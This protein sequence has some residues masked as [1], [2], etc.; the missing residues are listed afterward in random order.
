MPTTL[1]DLK[2]DLRAKKPL[3]LAF[4]SIFDPANQRQGEEYLELYPAGRTDCEILTIPIDWY[5][6]GQT[7]NWSLDLWYAKRQ[8]AD[9]VEDIRLSAYAFGASNDLGQEV[10][11]NGYLQA[12]LSTSLNFEPLNSGTVLS[13]GDFW[14]NSKKTVDFQF[15]MPIGALT[16]VGLNMIGLKI[17][18]LRS[19]VYGS[20]AWGRAMYGR[21]EGRKKDIT[22][23]L[24]VK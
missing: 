8:Q 7:R 15:N 6:K 13:L 16:L 18:L 19:V 5:E 4:T 14:P 9:R 17:E 21:Y 22:I 2:T 1:V 23:R 12:K 3:K 20:T 24:H 11:T 10:V